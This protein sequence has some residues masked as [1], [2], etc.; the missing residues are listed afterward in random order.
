MKYHPGQPTEIKRMWVA[1]DARGHGIG[2]RLLEELE[3]R[4]VESG[5]TVAHLETNASLVEAIAMYRK[6]GYREVEPFNDE[7]FADH[8]FEKR[9]T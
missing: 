8:W 2:R 5:A 3:K 9:F 7:P 1:R 6:A 4:V